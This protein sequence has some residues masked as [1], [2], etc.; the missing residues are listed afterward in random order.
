MMVGT[1]DV[2]CTC[3]QLL[4]M[5]YFPLQKLTTTL[6]PNWEKTRD[7]NVITRF[8]YADG[9][10]QITASPK[11]MAGP[12][13]RAAIYGQQAVCMFHCLYFVYILLPLRNS[14]S[15]GLAVGIFLN[16]LCILGE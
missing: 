8:Q 16:V 5:Q 9:Q 2:L 10:H 3:L 14:V 6:Q 11:E 4:S 12:G 7:G 13:W 15:L 1:R